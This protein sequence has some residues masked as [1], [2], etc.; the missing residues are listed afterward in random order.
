M[1]KEWKAAGWIFPPG[2]DTRTRAQGRRKRCRKDKNDRQRKQRKRRPP[3]LA[4]VEQGLLVPKVAQCNAWC[5][6]LCWKHARDKG[7]EEPKRKK[8]GVRRAGNEK[9]IER[10]QEAYGEP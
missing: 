7:L 8:E 2:Y 5:Q 4:C 6:G 3:C 10:A 9:E 1:K